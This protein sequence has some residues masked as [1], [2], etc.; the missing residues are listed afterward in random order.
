MKKV[1]FSVIAIFSALF[2]TAQ[3]TDEVSAVLQH[4]DEVSVYKG[5]TAL[6]LAH[7]AATD[8]DVITLSQGTFQSV[9][10]EKTLTILGAGF[11]NSNEAK[12]AVT[13]IDGNFCVGKTG[14]V[15]EG[16]L[17][18]GVKVVSNI[19]FKQLKDSKIQRCSVMGNMDFT[20]NIE[21]V[22]VKQCYFAQNLSGR[23]N[24]VANGLLIANCYVTGCINYFSTESFVNVDHSFMGSQYYTGADSDNLYAQFLWTNSITCHSTGW[25]MPTGHYS[26]VKNCIVVNGGRTISSN[27]IVENCYYVDLDKI[28]ADGENAA[29]SET[30]TF[31]L[32]DAATYVGTDG[33]PIGPSGGAGWNKVPSKPYVSNLNATVNGTN[34][35][36]TYESGVNK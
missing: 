32:Q 12:T 4:G 2:A 27:N 35:N 10:I 26:T 5:R 9:N 14:V 31:Q 33:T 18:E 11:E 28:F 20:E 23:T 3:S 22:T 8:G 17:M 24:I 25:N 7:A 34:L 16:F 6:Q 21:N 36:V 29:Y 30:R 13:A 19:S 1:L 15:I